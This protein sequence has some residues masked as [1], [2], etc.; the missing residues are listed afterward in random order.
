MTMCTKVWGQ[1]AGRA[2]H[3]CRFA[4]YGYNMCLRRAGPRYPKSNGHFPRKFAHAH[5][6]SHAV[7]AMWCEGRRIGFG[8][9]G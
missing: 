5:E 3:P 6:R 2:C 4:T 7:P 1:A 8:Q 9:L